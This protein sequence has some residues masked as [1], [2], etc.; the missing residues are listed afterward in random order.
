MAF[1]FPFFNFS[2]VP[3]TSALG[4]SACFLLFGALGVGVDGPAW[5]EERVPRENFNLMP[6]VDPVVAGVMATRGRC[7]RRG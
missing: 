5:F 3:L 1:T 4:A 6:D 2:P 7:D